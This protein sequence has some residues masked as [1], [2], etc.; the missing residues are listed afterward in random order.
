MMIEKGSE[1]ILVA[2]AVAII[3]PL[4]CPL[5][6]SVGSMRTSA[7]IKIDTSEKVE[8]KSIGP[9]LVQYQ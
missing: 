3:Q 4:C 5:V 2:F 8:E 7:R 9:R 1:R 6:V